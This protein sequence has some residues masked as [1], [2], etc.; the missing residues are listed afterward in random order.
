M[1]LATCSLQLLRDAS[2]GTVDIYQG[3]ALE[4]DIE[5]SC[6]PYVERQGW[7][8][9]MYIICAHQIGKCICIDLI[10]T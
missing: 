7:D 10:H 4:H 9:G 3:D 8:S 1:K 2:D 6:G 5:S